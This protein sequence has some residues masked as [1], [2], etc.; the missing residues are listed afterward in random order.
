M[1]NRSRSR[2]L[3]FAAL[4]TS[5]VTRTSIRTTPSRHLSIGW[6]ALVAALGG[7]LFGYD[8][9]IIAS[10]LPQITQEF[11]LDALEQSIVASSI[12]VGCIIGALTAGR[13]S[14][15][16]GRRKVLAGVAV[17]FILA[18]IAVALSHSYLLLVLFR[19]AL[20]VSVGA[21]SQV[22]PVYIAELAP[23]ARRGR[24][25]VMF[26][27]AVIFGILVSTV[28][29]F[30]IGTLDGGWRI[31][32]ALGAV[33]AIVMLVGSFLLPETPRFLVLSGKQE[34]AAEVL[35]RLRPP[36]ADVQTELEDII[37]VETE[38]RAKARGWREMFGKRVRPALIAGVGIA[39]FCQITG[40]NAILYYAPTI[41]GN[42]GFDTSGSLF[43]SML[44]SF[45]LFIFTLLG[46]FLIDRWGRRRLMLAFVPL[47]A[48]CII[49]LGFSFNGSTV[50]GSPVLLVVLLVL[51]NALNG[52]S[53]SVVAWLLASEVYPLAIR[54]VA[55]GF[56]AFALWA[57][58]LLVSLSSLWLAETL[59][60]RG[61]F[62]LFGLIGFAALAFVYFFA[63]ETKG[64][65]LENI[66]ESL[67]SGTFFP[68]RRRRNRN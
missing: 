40:I 53:L 47:S 26:Q 44:V 29:G 6:V 30:F 50:E 34:A 11:S 32:A 67:N 37:Q 5:A 25:V 63:P 36:A 18:A 66:E 59:T 21:A 65:S 61:M 19:I 27:V 15:R 55:M 24:L 14:D 35:R 8:T 46:L 54:G 52:G 10:A 2:R 43:T 17:L 28:S 38:S 23:A 64:R 12:L 4:S 16:I 57:A 33:P 3:A 22:V 13:I 39:V 42:A 1:N 58:D 56:T 41:L 68:R 45:V 51:G 31:T 49:A 9:G 7:L 20:G 48:I 62:W 60:I